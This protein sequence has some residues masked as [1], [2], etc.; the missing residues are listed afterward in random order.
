M[1]GQPQHSSGY[2]MQFA[3]QTRHPPRPGW[4][5]LPA[6]R[7]FGFDIWIAPDAGVLARVVFVATPTASSSWRGGLVGRR[8][9]LRAALR[10]SRIRSVNPVEAVAP[11]LGSSPSRG[12]D[13]TENQARVGR[14]VRK[15][16]ASEPRRDPSNHAGLD[17]DGDPRLDRTPSWWSLRRTMALG[18]HRCSA[19][20]IDAH[21]VGPGRRAR[22]ASAH[23]AVSR[24]RSR[25]ADPDVSAAPVRVERL[26]PAGR[27]SRTV[28]VRR[29]RNTAFTQ[30]V[31][32]AALRRP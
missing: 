3:S 9:H 25:R 16:E 22:R 5:G 26:A 32:V 31:M 19:P 6:T 12:G 14:W 2:G 27:R 7:V 18:H 13:G 1:R 17:V 10:F 29:M 11:C 8:H 4:R 30:R 21:G 15:A 28:I 20:R 23:C 24:G